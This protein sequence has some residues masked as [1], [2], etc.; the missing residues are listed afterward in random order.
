MIVVKIKGGLGNQMFE[1]AMA[2]KMQIDLGGRE[3]IALEMS[4]IGSDQQRQFE[5]SHFAFFDRG[6]ILSEPGRIV[7]IQ[8]WFRKKLVSYFIAGRA[9][10][11][12]GR[13]ENFWG[14]FF[15]LLGIVQRD[16]SQMR[17]SFWLRFHRNI[18]IN[19]WFQDASLF[20]PMREVLRKD[21][22]YSVPALAD[23][24][25]CRKIQTVNSVCVHVRRGDY[26][27]HPIFDVCSEAY[28]GRAMK[29]IAKKVTNPVFFVFSDDIG[30]VE[31]EMAFPYPV[32]YV[33]K[34]HEACDEMFLMRQCRHFILSN[35]TFSWW[36]QFLG[37]ASDKVV[38]APAKWRCLDETDRKIYM[39]E[40]ILVDV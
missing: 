20:E 12:A 27:N 6:M 8:E 33:R 40:W 9:E 19:G 25:I 31:R 34:R 7:R 13:R 32:I 11:I 39:D 18:Y 36:A 3:K 38:V 24:D 2:R 10:E 5:L 1:Y 30:Q 28:Y 16:H 21:F 23:T 37:E 17:E 22:A 15:A 29:C 35:S 26:V 14:T 4:V